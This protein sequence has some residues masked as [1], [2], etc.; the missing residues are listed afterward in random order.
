MK[1]APS[2][3]AADFSRLAQE[4]ARV[5]T[6]DML[7]LDVMDGVFVPNLSI[8][9]QVI[10]SLR[11]KTPMPFDVHLMLAHPLPYISAFRE[12]GADVITFHIE[13]EDDPEEVIRAIRETGAKPGIALKPKTGGEAIAPWGGM[14]YMVTIMTVEPGFGG[15]KLMEK[16]LEKIP[17]L[18][19]KFPHLLL[20]VDGGVNDVTAPLCKRAGADVLVAGTSVFGAKDPAAAIQRLRG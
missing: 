4:V 7:H 6:G 11:D 19:E 12:A 16:P 1:V 18:K 17:P 15:Q 14:L 8:G 9:P 13:C 20:E 2:L 5:K 10:K 3:L